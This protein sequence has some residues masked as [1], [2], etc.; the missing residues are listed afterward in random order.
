MSQTLRQGLRVAD[1]AAVEAGFR[2][3]VATYG[4]ERSADNLEDAVS[5][6]RIPRR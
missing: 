2:D 5:R 6:D 3:A 4:R 1:S